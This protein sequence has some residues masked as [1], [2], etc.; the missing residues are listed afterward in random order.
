MLRTLLLV[1]AGC[2]LLAQ[3]T[4]YRPQG[5]EIP[6]PATPAD[7]ASWLA[8]VQ[9][10]R[11]EKWIR[12]GYDGAEYARPAFKWT[13][14][15][16][17][18]PQMMAEERFFYDPVAR[19]YTVDRYL[20]DLDKRYGGIDSVLIWHVYPNIGI[21]NRSQFDMLRDMPGGTAGLKQM[22]A[23]FHRRGVKVFFPCMPWEHGTHSEGVPMW[24][25]VAR[26]MTEV[27]A[28]GVN[29]DTFDGLPHTFRVASDRTNHPIIFEPEGAPDDEALA[30]N[31]QSWGYW[32]Y[33][34]T[35]M[36]SKQ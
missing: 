12:A 20:D 9:N 3:D 36:I 34:K 2:A 5:E 11:I 30:W 18:Q 24:E 29:G 16:F 22:I 33:P 8:D 27:G 7:F 14:R 13:Q 31:N 32:N 26:Q 10:W 21:D 1:L 28:D 25:A 19:R 6:G 35:P 15:N 23:D 4:K 17:V